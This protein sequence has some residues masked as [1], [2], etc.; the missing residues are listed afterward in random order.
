M[1]PS[2][3]LNRRS[4][5]F[6]VTQARSQYPNTDHSDMQANAYVNSAALELSSM[7]PM[8]S[9]SAAPPLEPLSDAEMGDYHE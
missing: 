6:V 1:H 3:E 9:F 7:P 4:S 8:P 5:S 2:Q